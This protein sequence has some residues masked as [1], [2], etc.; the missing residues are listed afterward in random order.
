MITQM[1]EKLWKH[2]NSS[3]NNKVTWFPF[4][5]HSAGKRKGNFNVREIIKWRFIFKS[6]CVPVTLKRVIYL[7]SG[8]S[9]FLKKLLKLTLKNESKPNVLWLLLSTMS[10]LSVCKK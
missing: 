10:V 2:I 3:I 4:F 6:S 8:M 7:Q 9:K 5:I 1:I